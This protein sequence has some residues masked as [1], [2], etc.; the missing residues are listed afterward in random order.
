MKILA[1][2]FPII[3]L[4]VGILPSKVLAKKYIYHADNEISIDG[5]Q[6]TEWQKAN[7]Q[8]M[9]QLML[10]EAPSSEDFTGR[11]K[12]LW[13]RN[14]LYILAEIT[15][16]ILFDQHP[17]PL[18][19]Y[20]DDDCLEV[21]IDE[22]ASGGDHQ[23]NFNAFAYHIALDN[24]AVDI[25]ELLDGK[26]EN[27]ILLNDHLNSVWKRSST[28]PYKITWEV[29]LKVFDDS[30]RHSNR[31]TIKPQQ[32]IE[33]KNIGFM[34][35]YCDNDGSKEREHFI[36]SANIIAHNG[37]KNLGYKTADVFDKYI[38]IKNLK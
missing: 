3:F 17:D 18:F 27:F 29:A 36:G 25:G 16:D 22:D 2:T 19:K 32:L 14:Y 28:S 24:Q 21:F 38:L 4:L 8:P 33:G 12:L 31:K 15:D 20:W 9:N 10:G 11:F 30:Y 6:E 7:W 34:L 13:D 23:Y 35:A 26:K 5:V 37:D 1:V